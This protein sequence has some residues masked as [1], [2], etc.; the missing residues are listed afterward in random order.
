MIWAMMPI[1]N[2]QSGGTIVQRNSH[3]IKD[4]SANN[5]QIH[6]SELV[7]YKNAHHIPYKYNWSMSSIVR[8]AHLQSYPCITSLLSV[9]FPSYPPNLLLADQSSFSSLHISVHPSCFHLE[10]DVTPW[11]ILPFVELR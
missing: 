1:P 6:N 11:S 2:N 5:P 8:D 10:I 3:D 9:H 4:G 7:Y